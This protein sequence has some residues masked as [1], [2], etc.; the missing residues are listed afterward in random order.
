MYITVQC[1]TKG[2][3]CGPT[4]SL[5]DQARLKE[6]GATFHCLS[7]HRNFYPKGPGPKDLEI[8]RLKSQ[9]AAEERSSKRVYEMYTKEHEGRK[10]L[11]NAVKLLAKQTGPG[12]CPLKGIGTM[13]VAPCGKASAI[14]NTTQRAEES[15]A[16]HQKKHGCQ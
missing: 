4:L 1:A 15:L 13:W 3:P 8:T 14:F 9:L 11:L 2:C 16:R 5:E 6:S 7:G 10:R 12:I